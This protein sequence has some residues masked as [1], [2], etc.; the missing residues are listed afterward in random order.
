MWQRVVS[1]VVLTKHHGR[2]TRFSTL[3]TSAAAKVGENVKE[4]II[5]KRAKTSFMVIASDV[6]G[7][8][9]VRSGNESS[10]RRGVR[11]FGRENR[12]LAR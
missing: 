4:D 8:V 5:T 2:I 12:A 3:S 6:P 7:I 1:V 11:N 9:C 10:K